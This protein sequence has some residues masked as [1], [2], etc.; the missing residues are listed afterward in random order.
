MVTEPPLVDEIVKQVSL[1]KEKGKT[2]LQL[3]LQPAELGEITLT[4]TL[5]SGALQ[6][7]I[8]ALP[9]TRKLIDSRRDEL[10]QALKKLNINFTELIIEEVGK[11][12]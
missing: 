1:V 10:E 6:V 9:E 5:V 2:Q 7:A 11:N 8:C 3:T 4:L 12:V